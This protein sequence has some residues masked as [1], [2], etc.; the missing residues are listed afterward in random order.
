MSRKK[1]SLIGDNQSSCV[2]VDRGSRNSLLTGV[3]RMR[4]RREREAMISGEEGVRGE[5]ED[6]LEV[7]E[8]GRALWFRVGGC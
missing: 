7:E 1:Y 6:R 5:E 2:S 4:T 3:S 8:E